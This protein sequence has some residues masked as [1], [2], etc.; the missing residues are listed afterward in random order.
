MKCVRV[1]AHRPG[2]SSS[3]DG[4][5]LAIRDEINIWSSGGTNEMTSRPATGRKLVNSTT[6]NGQDQSANQSIIAISFV[7]FS[8]RW[9]DLK[10]Q[11]GFT[12]RRKTSLPMF[13]LSCVEYAFS[14]KPHLSAT[15][16]SLL[17]LGN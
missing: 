2:G 5:T 16:K 13:S 10:L 17:S 14:V 11:L 12:A 4:I 1:A 9:E 8:G 3:D 6:T 15:H 7:M